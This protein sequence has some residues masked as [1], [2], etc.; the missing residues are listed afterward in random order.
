MHYN[1]V[2]RNQVIMD[3]TNNAWISMES[4]ANYLHYNLTNPPVGVYSRTNQWHPNLFW[5]DILLIRMQQG[6]SLRNQ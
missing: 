2:I 3:T 6:Q 5:S 1:C 4:L